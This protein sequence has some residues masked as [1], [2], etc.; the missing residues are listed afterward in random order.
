MKAIDDAAALELLE[1]MVGLYSPSGRERALAEFLVD[2]MQEAGFSAR[3]DMVGNVVGN[4]CPIPDCT[5]QDWDGDRAGKSLLLLGHLDTVPGFIPPRR[6]G[7]RLY[8]RGAVDAKGPLAA[9]CVAAARVGPSRSGQMVVVGA[10]EEE[11]ATSKGARALLDCVDPQAVVIGEPS[12]WDRITVGYKGRLLVDLHLQGEVG[13]S[14]GPGEGLCEA[15]AAF[16]QMIREQADHWNEGRKRLFQRLDP[17]LRSVNSSS[18]GFV[19]RVEMTIGLRIP[20][21]FDV[22]IYKEQLSAR[23]QGWFEG[24]AAT[25][26]FRGQEPAFRASRATSLARAFLGA[27]RSQGGEPRFTVKTGTSDMNVVGPAWACPIVAYGPGDSS[28]DHTPG[29]HILVSEYLRSIRVLEEVLRE[30]VTEG[31]QVG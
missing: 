17:S 20:L 15:A 26:S 19:E 29:E 16:W 5:S 13:H 1:T 14:A 9:F 28:L 24:R 3:R 2:W 8:G 4:S 22:E 30:L 11:A 25:I 31:R 10:V 27:I 6:E 7:D 23:A 12:G 18:D 21:G